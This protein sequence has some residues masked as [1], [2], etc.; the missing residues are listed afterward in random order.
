VS[1]LFLD[2]SVMRCLKNTN[3]KHNVSKLELQAQRLRIVLSYGPTNYSSPNEI[4]QD[5]RYSCQNVDLK[6]CLS[7]PVLRLFCIE[8]INIESLFIFKQG[9]DNF[10]L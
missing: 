8:I 1:S 7:S 6:L 4:E 5:N 3:S 10:N 9:R 2:M